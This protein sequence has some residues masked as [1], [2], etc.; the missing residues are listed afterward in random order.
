MFK[1]SVQ[2]G[3]VTGFIFAALFLGGSNAALAGEAQDRCISEE[4]S[5][6]QEFMSVFEMGCIGS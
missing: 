2:L 1:K 6:Q 4:M 5:A 3:M